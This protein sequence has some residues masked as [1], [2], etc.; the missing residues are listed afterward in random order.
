[1]EQP[2]AEADQRFEMICYQ[3][4]RTLRA[5]LDLVDHEVKCPHCDC[6]QQVPKPGKN[7]ETP[8]GK[9]PRLS[10]NRYFNFACESCDSLLEAHT[11][12]SGRSAVCP[13]CGVR[14][15]VPYL[16]KNGRPTRAILIDQEAGSS[17]LAPVH[18]YAASGSL[19]PEILK[20]DDGMTVIVCPR[21]KVHNEVDAE[22]CVGCGTPFSLDGAPTGSAKSAKVLAIIAMILGVLS[23]PGFMFVLP[24]FLAI[25][26]GIFGWFGA[27]GNRR[28][29]L[30]LVAICL[31]SLSLVTAAIVYFLRL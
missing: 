10:A 9:L 12:L 14:F 21:C 27:L 23:L 24:G 3:C 15:E 25:V 19:A 2:R 20:L 13:T 29:G 5:P 30:A 18:A 7:G 11:G 28:S 31:G 8:V 1:M 17:D 4:K 6:M 26:L 16:D 22:H